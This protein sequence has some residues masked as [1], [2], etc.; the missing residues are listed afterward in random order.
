MAI[1]I[2]INDKVLHCVIPKAYYHNIMRG[3]N[4]EGHSNSLFHKD[5]IYSVF[6]IVIY[7]LSADDFA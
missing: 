2:A 4:P 3:G 6:E 7:L 1:Y 5:A